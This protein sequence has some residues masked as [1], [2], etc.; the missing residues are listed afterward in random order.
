[1]HC[2][3]VLIHSGCCSQG[4][5]TGWLHTTE[6][7]S[8]MVLEVGSLKAQSWEG[9]VPP[10]VSRGESFL[11]YSYL[12]LF[13]KNRLF[14]LATLARGLSCSAACGVTSPAQQGG[15]LTTGPP[16]EP[17]PLPAFWQ[18]LGS[19]VFLGLQP[20]RC[21]LC[22]YMA[23][24]PCISAFTQPYQDAGHWVWAPP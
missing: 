18:L 4:P 9:H 21:K 14:I 10:E 11:S 1:M 2:D 20:Q 7:C 23:F 19:L 5:H 15:F 12:L 24:P 22:S 3:C 8:V 13:W 6:M 16:G 17:L